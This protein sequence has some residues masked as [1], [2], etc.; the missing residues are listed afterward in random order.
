MSRVG[1]PGAIARMQ[2]GV[3]VKQRLLKT[4]NA[5]KIPA[6]GLDIFVVRDFLS[7]GECAE[8]IARIDQ[9]RV[10]SGLLAPTP[11]PEF[12]TSESCN[13]RL[14]D[15]V[16][17]RVERKINALMGIEPSHGETIQ[18]QRYA[19]G[20]QFK[21]HH[22]FFFTTEAY[23]PEMDRQGGQRTWTAMIFL[24][25][26]EAGGQTY[27]PRANVRVSPRAGNL[28]AWNNLDEYGEPN[29]Y[30]LHTG[31]P[32]EAG[33]KYVITKWYRERPW[34]WYGQTGAVPNAPY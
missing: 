34:G 21:P 27:F 5:L 15:P 13:L 10:P 20:Q 24:N 29:G 12:R 14:E 25:D 33:V 2:Y 11:D 3:T 23:W 16:N 28:L 26:V 17:Q 9:D 30:S 6:Q 19:V 1:D 7:R 32:V 31:C 18:G 22:D 4:P 8:V